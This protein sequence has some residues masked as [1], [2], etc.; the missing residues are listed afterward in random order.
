M[1]PP[2]FTKPVKDADHWKILGFLMAVAVCFW[3]NYGQQFNQRVI[4]YYDAV[5][6]QTGY[7]GVASYAAEHGTG[8]TLKWVW[9]QSG[10]N[11]VLY[12]VFA[13]ILGPWVSSPI[14]GLFVYLLGIHVI[15]TG[16]LAWTVLRLTKSWFAV[17]G[18]TAVWLGSAQFG[19]LRG[20]IGDQRMDLSSGSMYLIVIA[21]GVA[22]THTPTRKL[23]GL[24]GLAAA[25]AA[26]HRPVL[27]AALVGVAPMLTLA[28]YL[29]HRLTFRAWGIQIAWAVCPVLIL[30]LPWLIMHREGLYTYYFEYGPAIG[31]AKSWGLAI[32]FTLENFAQAVGL[33]STLLCIGGLAVLMKYHEVDGWRLAMVLLIG[34]LPLII[35]MLSRSVGN[36]F[37]QQMSLG[38]PALLFTSFDRP[39]SPPKTKG[40]SPGWAL[41]PLAIVVLLIPFRLS[42]HLGGESPNA[43][44]EVEKV[45]TEIS[46]ATAGG[47]IAGFHDLPVSVVSLVAVANT[48]GSTLREGTLSYFP[49]DFGL[50]K[51]ADIDVNSP[52]FEAAIK[53]RLNT[54]KAHNELLIIPTAETSFRLWK[55]LY[56]HRIL[57]PLRDRVSEDPDFQHIL[58]TQAVQGVTFDIFK[59]DPADPV[60]A[61]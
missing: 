48:M 33:G 11:V 50:S 41:L 43:R 24:A 39:K 4:P 26:L 18:A 49:S 8:A 16:V 51:G 2:R 55:G 61:R 3:T 23:A 22:W 47:R 12:K 19:V 59:I 14:S 27:A 56:S 17:Y 13:A 45:V 58:V 21:L 38:L 46:A 6:Y 25:L 37:V 15:A 9:T 20:G 52:E 28:V 1:L 57:N 42:W 40:L 60:A 31:S 30:C 32:G 29:R 34:A 53:Q 35:L 44:A 54:L 10:N 7:Q 36:V 5:A